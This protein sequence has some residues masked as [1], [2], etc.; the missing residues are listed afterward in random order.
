VLVGAAELPGPDVHALRNRMPTAEAA[1]MA[2]RRCDVLIPGSVVTAVIVSA[3]SKPRWHPCYH[4]LMPF[5]GLLL[6]SCRDES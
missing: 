2:R 5:G 6:L 3:S 1:A 4:D